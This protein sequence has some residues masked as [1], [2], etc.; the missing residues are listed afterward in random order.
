MSPSEIDLL[1][2]QRSYLLLNRRPFRYSKHFFDNAKKRGVNPNDAKETVIQGKII[3]FHDRIVNGKVIDKRVLIRSSKIYKKNKH[4]CVVYS[5]WF[6]KIITAYYNHYNDNHQTL[7]LS[8]Y[9]GRHCITLL[10]N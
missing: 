2:M 5:L 8:Q 1:E 7:D 10:R 3:E 9:N 6:K 4:L